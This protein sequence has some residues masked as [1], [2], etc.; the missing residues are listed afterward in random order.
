MSTSRVRSCVTSSAALR[1]WSAESKQKQGF[2]GS[3]LLVSDFERKK[4][5]ID[6]LR[7]DVEALKAKWRAL[8]DIS[9]KA[10]SVERAQGRMEYAASAA[11]QGMFATGQFGGGSAA[12]TMQADVAAVDTSDEQPVQVSS[13][14]KQHC[15]FF[16]LN[17]SHTTLPLSHFANSSS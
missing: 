11:R 16:V 3:D 1:E 7:D 6:V 14:V 8:N 9:L 2:I 17:A 12:V 10:Q 13:C 5:E 15:C 4:G